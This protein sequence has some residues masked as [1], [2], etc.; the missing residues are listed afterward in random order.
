M[1]KVA[2]VIALAAA[3]VVASAAVSHAKPL[4][5]EQTTAVAADSGWG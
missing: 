5:A 1:R 2:A 4:R 3:L